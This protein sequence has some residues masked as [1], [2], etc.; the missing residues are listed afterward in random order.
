MAKAPT[1]KDEATKRGDELLRRLLKTP[2]QVDVINPA[3][4]EVLGRVPRMGAEE[5]TAGVEAASADQVAVKNTPP[6]SSSR[7]NERPKAQPS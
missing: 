1:E 5:A 7:I 4:A 2:P 6:T 3:N